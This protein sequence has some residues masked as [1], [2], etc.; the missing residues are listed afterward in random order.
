MTTEH[1]GRLFTTLMG[2][3]LNRDGM[4]IELNSDDSSFPLMEAFY[5]D[6]D[7]SF[8]VTGFGRPIP[9]SVVEEF[10]REARERLPPIQGPESTV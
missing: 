10:V 6:A 1:N 8:A 2:S 9:I 7:S 3:D 5:C 4:F